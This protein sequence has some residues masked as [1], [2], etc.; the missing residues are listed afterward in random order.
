VFICVK[1]VPD[2]LQ[3]FVEFGAHKLEAR[4]ADA[5]VAHPN[6][7]LDQLNQ[8]HELRHRIHAQQ[9]QEPVVQRDRLLAFTIHRIVEQID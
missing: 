8:L 6:F 3:C 1:Y 9:R 5:R 7:L 2:H 4:R